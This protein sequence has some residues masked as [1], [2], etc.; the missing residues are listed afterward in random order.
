MRFG[1]AFWVQRTGWPEIRDACIAAEA[2]GWNSIWVDDH[3]LADEG[4]WRDAKLEGW[5]TLAAVAAVTSRVRLGVLVSAATLRNI[6]LVAKLATTLDHLSGGRAV[7]G[8]GGGWFE[9][10]HD[11]F[12]LDF[13]AGFGERIER[14]AEAVPL[15]RRLLDGERVTFSGRH[16]QLRDAVCAPRPVQAR[17]PIL[18]GGSGRRRTLPLVAAHADL[19]NGYG[20][21]DA[22][23]SVS[24]EL[25]RRCAERGRPFDSLER[26]VMFDA[27][28]RVDE[29]A[30][31]ASWNHLA[32]RHGLHGRIAADGTPRGLQAWGTPDS[33]AAGV[34]RYAEHGIAELI[35]IFRSPFDL[36]SIRRLPEVRAALPAQPGR[37]GEPRR[38]S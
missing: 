3:L 27:V 12:G 6:G 22:I 19:W 2:A 21:P 24:D 26:T 5:T 20:E 9:R 15:V 4:D 18:V 28:L 35:W 34:A 11:A 10:E 14:L 16:H 7:L 31:L 36:E 29:A 30:A 32:D 1:A 17:L 38:R 8:L 23:A 25:R 33:I 37:A 13:G